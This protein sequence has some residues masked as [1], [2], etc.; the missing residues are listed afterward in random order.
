MCVLCAWASSLSLDVIVVIANFD[1]NHDVTLEIYSAL[2]WRS[3]LSW[4]QKR[5]SR[6]W[7][8]RRPVVLIAECRCCTVCR[9]LTEA[10][11]HCVIVLSQ[12]HQHLGLCVQPT[13]QRYV[14]RHCIHVVGTAWHDAVSHIIK[15]QFC[16]LSHNHTTSKLKAKIS[17]NFPD[18]CVGLTLWWQGIY[19]L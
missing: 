15:A 5:P 12:Y 1:H 6:W 8:I 3:H 17:T 7:Y 9:Y 2:S 19:I 11:M 13:P 14:N 16:H 4:V 10:F 18:R